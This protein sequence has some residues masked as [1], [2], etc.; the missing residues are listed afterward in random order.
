MTAVGLPSDSKVLFI[1]DAQIASSQGVRRRVHSARKYEGNPIVVSDQD[2]E[3]PAITLGTVLMEDNIYRMWYQSR[4]TI[5]GSNSFD[6]YLRFLHL[7]SESQDGV[8]WTKPALGLY[9][10]SKGSYENNITFIRP[11]FNRDMN[12]S[13][14]H[15]PNMWDGHAY[16]MMTYG[17]GHNLPYDGYYVAFSNDGIRWREGSETPVIP[18]YP[19]TGWFTYDDQGGIF[20]GSLV[21]DSVQSPLYTES[22][23]GTSWSLPRPT[24]AP[25]GEDFKLVES[26]VNNKI[27]FHAMPTYRYGPFLLG[28]LQVLQG[29][30]ISG[31]GFD[32][33]MDV[34]LVS[35]RDGRSWQRVA[36]RHSILDKGKEGSWDS[37][38]VW[39]GNSL[40]VNEDKVLAYYTGCERSPGTLERNSK[41]KSIGMAWWPIDRFAGLVADGN[42]E[43][44]TYPTF[45]NGEI[46][47]NADASKGS[48][49]AE[50]LDKER[51]PIKGFEA[52]HCVALAGADSL[53]HT[54]QWRDGVTRLIDGQSVTIRLKLENS[55]VF[56]VWWE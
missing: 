56:S 38:L 4:G 3:A 30:E 29:R 25:E 51:V 7:Y 34:E 48:I 22:K 20:R 39:T 16:A 44:E 40:L 26:D 35:S 27:L 12:T 23:D 2:W 19:E 49:V 8:T 24:V 55:E 50:L 52:S 11:T 18:G 33:S 21:W 5:P 32:G 43:I 28:F 37:G 13:V 42:G 6:S 47:V 46:H 1:D 17:S 54:L 10:D 14:L 45:S 15:T 53:N 41:T 36:P 31:Q 9:E